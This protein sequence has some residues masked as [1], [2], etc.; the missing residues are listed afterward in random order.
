M[1]LSTDQGTFG[2]GFAGEFGT[3]TAPEKTTEGALARLLAK[4]AFASVG[5]CDDCDSDIVSDEDPPTSASVPFALRNSI[6]VMDFPTNGRRCES[7]M[8]ICW[9]PDLASPR[10][11]ARVLPA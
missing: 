10:I 7:S 6:A 1:T 3:T 8:T 2:P 4:T 5:A 11:D 9:R